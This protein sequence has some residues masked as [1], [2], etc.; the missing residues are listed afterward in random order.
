MLIHR[1]AWYP[2]I[3]G[4]D[5]SPYSRQGQFTIVPVLVGSLSAE[6]EGE[7]GRVFSKYLSD[8][9]NLFV[10][11]SDFCHWGKYFRNQHL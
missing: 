2:N 8:P 3:N 1:L 4:H 10:I 6:M 9:R 5:I 11:S 7:F